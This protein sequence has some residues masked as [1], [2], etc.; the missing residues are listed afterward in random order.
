MIVVGF[1]LG[2]RTTVAREAVVVG[3]LLATFAG[4]TFLSM[5]WAADAESAFNEF[6][7]TSLYLA[8]LVLAVIT[9]RAGAAGRWSDGLCAGIVAIAVLALSSRLFPALFESREL[10]NFIPSALTRLSFPV[11]YWNALGILVSLAVPLCLRSALVAR[12]PALRAL[13]VAVVPVLAGVV[14]LTSSRGAVVA[15]FVGI[16]VFLVMTDVRWAALG[17]TMAAVAGSTLA[18]AV[19]IDRHT[20]VNGPLDSDLAVRQGRTAAA[21]LIICCLVTA[22]LQLVGERTLRGRFRPRPFAGW[23]VAGAV[24]LVVLVGLLLARPVTRFEEF[25]QPP[26]NEILVASD[27]ATAHL[28][29]GN[30]SGRWQFWTAAIDEFES[31]PLHG[32]GAGSYESWWAEH[33]SFTYFLKNAHS[34]YLEVLGELGLVGFFLLV[35]VF[36]GGFVIAVRRLRV[37]RG[38]SRVTLAALTAVLAAFMAAAAIDWIWQVTVV[39]VVGIAALGLIVGPATLDDLGAERPVRSKR[40]RIA[41]GVGLLGVAW[42]LICAQ[43]IPWLATDKIEDSQAAVRRGNL[44]AALKDALDAKSLQPWA[45][46]TY[47]Q[48]ALVAETRGDLEASH[49]WIS[50]AIQRNS[51]DWRLWLVA[52]RI[53]RKSGLHEQADRSY[54]KARSLNPRSP[55]FAR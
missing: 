45:A 17:A 47:V 18:I 37:V 28:L 10:G 24:V 21:L 4:W 15:V 29:S 26:S 27:F 31:A 34:L 7:R 41:A 13:A 20:L 12:R 6:N 36:T 49:H 52:S 46:S 23:T 19:L 22:G 53:E 3:G 25:R 14:Y 9:A 32:R 44:N 48:I 51:R 39:G 33:A 55:L 38:Q 30:G 43:A 2:P 40:S 16:A 54:V 5:F 42:L 1:G 8:V 35:A 50:E 11:G